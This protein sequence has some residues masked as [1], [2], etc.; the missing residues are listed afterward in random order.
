MKLICIASIQ[1][2]DFPLS[3]EAD[4][5]PRNGDSRIIAGEEMIVT[6]VFESPK[7]EGYDA[8]VLLKGRYDEAAS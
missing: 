3:I 6:S 1:Y 7:L 8:V 4:W 2:P 5:I